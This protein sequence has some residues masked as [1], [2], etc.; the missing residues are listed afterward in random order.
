M[1]GYRIT[2]GY[3]SGDSYKGTTDEAWEALK[4]AVVSMRQSTLLAEFG[5]FNDTRMRA[6]IDCTATQLAGLMTH[7]RG[8]DASVKV[9]EDDGDN[10]VVLLASGGDKSRSMKEAMRRAYIR[11]IMREMHRQGIEI[12]VRVS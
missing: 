4:N 2:I 6:G 8:S 7:L 11:V 10:A 12:S 5:I 3:L 1:T 9:I